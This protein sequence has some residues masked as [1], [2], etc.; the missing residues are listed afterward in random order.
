MAGF[1]DQ[2]GH[3]Q[4]WAELLGVGKV[5][6]LAS[7]VGYSRSLLYLT[8]YACLLLDQGIVTL[9]PALLRSPAF[10]AEVRKA[11]RASLDCYGHQGFPAVICRTAALAFLQKEGGA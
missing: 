3:L 9:S 8:M 2:A 11:R 10:A 7:R 6:A 5:H 4:K 1:P